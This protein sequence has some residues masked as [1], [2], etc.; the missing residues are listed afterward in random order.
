MQ[1][2]NAIERFSLMKN[3]PIKKILYYVIKLLIHCIKELLLLL[4]SR[5]HDMVLLLEIKLFCNDLFQCTV[6]TT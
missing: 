6:V 4:T 2:R 5:K 1:A 3:C